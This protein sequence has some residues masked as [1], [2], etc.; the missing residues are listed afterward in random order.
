MIR[1]RKKAPVMVSPQ[2]RAALIE[3]MARQVML[4]LCDSVDII[5]GRH[6]FQPL[7]VWQMQNEVLLDVSCRVSARISRLRTGD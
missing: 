6:N 1:Y 2:Q 5:A 7:D 3:Q 4:Q